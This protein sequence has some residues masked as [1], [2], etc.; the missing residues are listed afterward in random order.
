MLICLSHH[1]AA[2]D[3]GTLSHPPNGRVDVTT[4]TFGSAALY[5]CD[6][7]YALSGSAM[8]NCQANGTWSGTE[9]T[10]GEPVFVELIITA[11]GNSG[12][13]SR[14]LVSPLS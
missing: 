2:V 9:P 1:I 14:Y 3:C 6:Q 5:D 7:G 4:T 8:R 13:N 12:L 11:W 10:C